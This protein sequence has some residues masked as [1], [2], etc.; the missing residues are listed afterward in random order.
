MNEFMWKHTR[1]P[2]ALKIKWKI[3]VLRMLLQ[4]SVRANGIAMEFNIVIFNQ[5]HSISGQPTAYG[6]TLRYEQMQIIL[7]LKECTCVRIYREKFP[8]E[9][10]FTNSKIR[11]S[12]LFC[13]R[14]TMDKSTIPIPCTHKSQTQRRMFKGSKWKLFYLLWV[15]SP[16]FVVVL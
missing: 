12:I 3:T 10:I 8:I 2:E 9:T 6:K 13:V 4:T 7:N 14:F 16:W 1:N 15:F 5:S 11:M